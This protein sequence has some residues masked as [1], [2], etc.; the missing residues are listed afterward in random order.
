MSA[1]IPATLPRVHAITNDEIL[2]DPGF[3]ARAR[4]V[5]SALGPRGAVHLRGHRSKGSLLHSHA[6]SLLSLQHETGCWL[7]V[8]DRVDVALS[9][10]V[11]AIQL[12]ST[13]LPIEDVRVLV[14]DAR[15]GASVHSDIEAS[16]AE[17]QGA[18]W[19]VA[20]N[21]YGTGTHI[22]RVGRGT[23]FLRGIAS[24]GLPVIAI[25][26]I[27]PEHVPDLASGGAYGVAMI[28]GIWG[29]DN[30]EAAARRYLSIYDVLAGA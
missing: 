24:A 30:A 5:M 12:T 22:G 21:V 18:E 6:T 19:V 8:N 13:S 7:V 2:A 25:G 20:G 15:I 26:G 9:A 4:I 3:L 10:G 1:T 11:R 29:A 17:Q 14:R 16:N 27:R 28:R 23:G